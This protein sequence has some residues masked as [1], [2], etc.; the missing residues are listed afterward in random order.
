MPEIIKLQHGLL[1]I[2]LGL[3]KK[4]YTHTHTHVFVCVCIPPSLSY[5]IYIYIC[6]CVCV[7]VWR[8]IE[9]Q[10]NP[11]VMNI[12]QRIITFGLLCFSIFLYTIRFIFIIYLYIYI[13]IYITDS[14]A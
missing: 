1:N 6:V 10:S 4:N 7:C 8:K 13:Y 2:F 14:L 3:K 11:K 5:Y 12:L 9:K